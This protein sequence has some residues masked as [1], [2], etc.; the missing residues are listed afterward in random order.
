MAFSAFQWTISSF[1]SESGHNIKADPFMWMLPSS[2]P[3][4]T[5]FFFLKKREGRNPSTFGEGRRIDSKGSSG[6]LNAAFSLPTL[7]GRKKKNQQQMR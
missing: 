6:F 5:G 2:S 3:L 4:F 1:I 7:R